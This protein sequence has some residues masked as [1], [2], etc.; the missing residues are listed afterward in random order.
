MALIAGRERTPGFKLLLA[1]LIGLALAIPLFSVWAL[2]YDRQSQSEE[3]TGSITAGWGGPQSITGP[4]LVIPYRAS[5]TETVIQNGQSVTRSTEVVRELSLAAEVA[6][7]STDIRPERRKRSIY[8]AVVYD[9]T[10]RGRARFAFPADLDRTGVDPATMDLS[11]AELRFGLSDPRGLGGNP[12]VSVGGRPLRLQPGGGSSGGRGFFAWIDAGGLRNAPLAVDYSYAFRGN[13]SIALAPEA[14]ETRWTVRSSWPHPSFGGEFLPDRRTISDSGFSASYRVGNLA[15]GRSLVSTAERGRT[16]G[17]ERVA[18]P[19][20]G[21]AAETIDVTGPGAPL[22][23]AAIS[24]IQ[25]VDP[26]SQV[27]RATKYGFL[28]IGFTFLALLMFDVVAGVRVSPVEY[29]LMGAALVLFFVLLLAFAEILGFTPAYLLA[30]AAVVGL[31][32]AY[33]AAIL[34]S[35]R[36][37]WVIGGLLAGLYAVLYVLLSLEAFSL[38]IGSLLLFAA[39]AG[40]M[41]AT[42]RLDWS[43][44]RRTE[45]D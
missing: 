42:R 29:L 18:P 3:A 25:P 35:W 23:T 22:Q 32:T 10:V 5:A 45:A 36:R 33:S 44:V 31:N 2:V 12:Q 11:R 41:Y 30:S 38:L 24:L 14:G 27:D 15:L 17:A 43:A 19:A 13:S 37:A 16:S 7:V 8:E 40:V 20:R 39:L 26:Y 34:G 4:V 21:P 6:E 28:F 9:S 1:I